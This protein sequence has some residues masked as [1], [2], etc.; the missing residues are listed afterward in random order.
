MAAGMFL[1]GALCGSLIG[2]APARLPLLR[3]RA[4]RNAASPVMQLSDDDAD[5]ATA[6]SG[7][8]GD[9]LAVMASRQL[10]ELSE[11]LHTEKELDD[12]VSGGE[13]Q[14]E[15]IFRDFDRKLA[16][17]SRNVSSELR[18]RLHITG[19]VYLKTLNATAE[20]LD[21]ALGPTRE[22][23]RAERARYAEEDELR[24]RAKE[25]RRFNSRSAFNSRRAVA[26]Q[27]WAR[28]TQH[29]IV[30]IN[31]F[32]ALIFSMLLLVAGAD[33]AM[34]N[35]GLLPAIFD[36]AQ[37]QWAA[38]AWWLA[39]VSDLSVYLLTVSVIL[40]GVLRGD[41]WATHAVGSVQDELASQRMAD[42][43]R[44]SPDLLIRFEYDWSRME[45]REVQSRES[46][47]QPRTTGTWADDGEDEP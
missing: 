21:V 13:A 41:E 9:L 16:Y 10:A 33:V 17:N 22:R 34:S 12:M 43:R 5:N 31:F 11:K 24:R 18:D 30:A 47:A 39:L 37:Q 40:G 4:G 35:Q 7:Y 15:A 3:P 8:T 19:L 2:T 46:R 23:I 6:M 14:L 44:L 20:R 28:S 1:V 38:G 45:W 26:L 32:S 25:L 27:N 36:S 29:P 42:R